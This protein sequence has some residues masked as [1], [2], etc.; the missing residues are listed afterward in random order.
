MHC[1]HIHPGT[2]KKATGEICE[3]FVIEARGADGC[4]GEPSV[5]LLDG[6]MLFLERGRGGWG[7]RGFVQVSGSVCFLVGFRLRVLSVLSLPPSL[8]VWCVIVTSKGPI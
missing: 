4:I 1:N 3:A 5:A 6:E 2:S 8:V 7:R